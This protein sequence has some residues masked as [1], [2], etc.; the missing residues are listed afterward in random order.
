MIVLICEELVGLFF[1]SF[2]PPQRPPPPTS[3][4]SLQGQ[5]G[6]WPLLLNLD[7]KLFWAWAGVIK[8]SLLKTGRKG[9]SW[10]LSEK[11]RNFLK[12]LGQQ[13]R[14]EITGF[15]LAVKGRF[16]EWCLS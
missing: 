3:L 13:G 11:P 9:S 1:F 15:F 12:A 10:G 4:S 16:R 14:V 8:L 2:S 5:A 7:L 6:A